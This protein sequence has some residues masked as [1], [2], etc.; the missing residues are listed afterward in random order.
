MSFV[1]LSP[2]V[3]HVQKKSGKAAKWDVYMSRAL[4]FL[5]LD[6]G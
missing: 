2:A 6:G 5:P 3:E 1:K 4:I